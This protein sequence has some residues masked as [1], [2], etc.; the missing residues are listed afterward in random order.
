MKNLKK[1][2]SSILAV[3][4]LAGSAVSLSCSADGP[5]ALASKSSK[6]IKL[7]KHSTTKKQT[8]QQNQNITLTVENPKKETQPGEYILK[9]NPFLKKEIDELYN[10]PCNEDPVYNCDKALSA[11][12]SL[13]KEMLKTNKNDEKLK[14]DINLLRQVVNFRKAKLKGSLTD[15]MK[16]EFR[17]IQNNLKDSLCSLIPLAL[18][19]GAIGLLVGVCYLIGFGNIISFASKASGYLL[20]AFELLLEFGWNSFTTILYDLLPQ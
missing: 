20:S 4:L 12:N 13:E 16:K 2:V 3:T 15:S 11:L 6:T 8:G 19:I 5:N 17:K 7:K 9:I 18:K 1:L 10:P 14:N